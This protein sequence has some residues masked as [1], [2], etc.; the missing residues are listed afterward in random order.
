MALMYSGRI[1]RVAWVCSSSSQAKN[2]SV[3]AGSVMLG[4]FGACWVFWKHEI[5]EA[6]V[7]F[8]FCALF[9]GEPLVEARFRWEPPGVVPWHGE[10]V[11][12]R[13]G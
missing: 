10:R 13:P 1:P 7:V 4:R 11:H 3:H 9:L 5:V 12:C 8:A 2:V 6:F